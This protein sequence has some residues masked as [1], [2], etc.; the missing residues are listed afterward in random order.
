MI[1]RIDVVLPAPLGPMKPYNAPRGMVRSRCS[2]AFSEPKVFV[3]PLSSI[4]AL[5]GCM[6]L[7]TPIRSIPK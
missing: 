1:M 2:T 7:E 6:L 3:T 4:A 5:L